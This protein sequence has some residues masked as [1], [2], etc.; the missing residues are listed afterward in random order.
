MRAKRAT[1]TTHRL[2]HSDDHEKRTAPERRGP[3]GDPAYAAPIRITG[4]PMLS[5]LSPRFAVMPEPGK[6]INPFGRRFSSSSFLRNG[7]AFP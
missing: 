6:R 2:A 7:A 5:A 1:R 3:V 4:M